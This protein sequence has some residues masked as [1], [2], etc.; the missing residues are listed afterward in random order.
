MLCLFIGT[1]SIGKRHA[2]N[3]FTIDP[4]SRFIFVRKNQLTDELSES[5]NAKIINNLSTAISLQPGIAVIS[6]P[7]AL[8]FETLI[9]LLE[10]KIPL[11]IEKPI[12][13]QNNHIDKL[14]THLESI[15]YSETTMVG[16][17]LRFLPSLLKVRELIKSNHLGKIVR[18]SF[19]VGQ[20]LPDWRPSQNYRSSYSAQKSMGGGVI[21][22]LIHELDMARWLFGEFDTVK[23]LKGKFSSLE[24][25]SED[26]AIILLG[27]QT[28]S[29]LVTVSM[30]Y[31]SRQLNRR[32]EIVGEKG[33]LIW[34][35]PKKSLDLM[36]P[37]CV[38]SI[39]CGPM[40]FDVSQTYFTA[41]KEFLDAVRTKSQTS[42][43]IQEGLKS[44][45][46]AVLANNGGN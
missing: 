29:P 30:D 8:H 12:V 7:S 23:S 26:T 14:K 4:N 33:T 38:K 37:D 36:L 3:L 15:Q 17:N 44:A 35:L 34:D 43:D 16:C 9:P 5:L 2:N 18:A 39:N 41:M 10:A 21:M 25:D 22:D 46:L 32:Y 13:T 45:A 40:G 24:I 11:Y 27:K 6:N 20:W 42:Q 1:G 28:G 19:S 31:V